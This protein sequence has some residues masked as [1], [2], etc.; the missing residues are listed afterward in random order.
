ML[1]DTVD[2]VRGELRIIDQTLLPAKEEIIS[3][4]DVDELAEA[5]LSLRVRGAPA[6][7]IA[8]A[9]GV[10]LHL[11]NL[12]RE[13]AGGERR[14]FFDRKEGTADFDSSS[15]DWDEISASLL[16]ASKHLAGT[17]PTAVNLFWALDRMNGTIKRS[18]SGVRE[19]CAAVAREAF[20][21]HEETLDVEMRIGANGA[22]LIR[23]GMNLL[24]HCNAGGL[25]TAGYGTALGVFYAA[26]EQGKD[27]SVFAG[28]TRPLLQGARLTAWELRRAGI[29]ATVFCDGAAASLIGSGRID[30][31]VTG[32]DRIA[33]NGDT[34]NKIGTLALA[35]FCEREGIPFYIAAPLSTFDRKMEDG[36][37]IPV[38][39]RSSLE[40]QYIQG[41]KIMP[42]GVGTYNPAFDITPA[43]LVTGFITEL[44]ILGKP[45]KDNIRKMLGGNG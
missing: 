33:L 10:L 34:A 39:E 17:R 36:G 16:D 29:K 22:E 30:L 35:I 41:V 15:L 3:L 11:E 6:I 37:Q 21:I 32:A 19:N 28:E 23:D 14:Y 26:A 5:I 2:Y 12:L 13:K 8:A 1:I 38:E 44:G 25:A 31:A 40:L 24:T 27:F 4:G 7:G 18:R 42:D 45:F 20:D 43:G 9:Y